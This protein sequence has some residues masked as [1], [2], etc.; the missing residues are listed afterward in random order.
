ML[1]RADFGDIEVKF[2]LYMTNLGLTVME[3]AI[4]VHDDVN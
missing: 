2:I 3:E 4:K 1:K